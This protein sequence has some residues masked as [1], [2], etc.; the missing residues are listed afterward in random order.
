MHL[1]QSK[2]VQRHVDMMVRADAKVPKGAGGLQDLK[3]IVGE[4]EKA[5]Q[6]I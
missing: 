1:A 6:D 3:N 5:S 2:R 4:L